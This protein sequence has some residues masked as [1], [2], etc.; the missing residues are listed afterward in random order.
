LERVLRSLQLGRRG[1]VL[2]AELPLL[3]AEL[4]LELARLLGRRALVGARELARLQSL[5]KR[6]LLRGQR[7]LAR[8]WRGVGA[9][10]RRPLLL[11]RER[12]HALASRARGRQGP[13]QHLAPF[14]RRNSCVTVDLVGIPRAARVEERLVGRE[15]PEFPVCDLAEG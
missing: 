8:R 5:Q 2:L 3:Q 13:L 4:L 7:L 12:R 1:Q 10:Q 11:R 14:S 9:E 6:L 15:A